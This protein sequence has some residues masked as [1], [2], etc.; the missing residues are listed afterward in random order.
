[1]ITSII[2]VIGLYFLIGSTSLFSQI[3][4]MILGVMA[5]LMLLFMISAFYSSESSIVQ[6]LD[7][8]LKEQNS[9]RLA[10]IN[11]AFWLM[12]SFGGLAIFSFYENKIQWAITLGIM[13]IF[14]LQ[15]LFFSV[16]LQDE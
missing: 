9:D 15:L 6:V 13:A 10:S 2:L 7:D 14:W 8:S 5:F 4:L 11:N 12:L 3:V 1:M 16:K